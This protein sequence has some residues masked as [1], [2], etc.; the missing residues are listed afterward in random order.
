M[1]FTTF[2]LSSNP[3]FLCN[4][5]VSIS[6][7][8]LI[9]TIIHQFYFEN[10]HSAGISGR[11]DSINACLPSSARRI[12]KLRKL[13][14]SISLVAFVLIVPPLVTLFISNTSLWRIEVP[15]V[16]AS[17]LEREQS[18]YDWS[19]ILEHWHRHYSETSWLFGARDSAPQISA[20]EQPHMPLFRIYISEN[21][22]PF[23]LGADGAPFVTHSTDLEIPD[24]LPPS[25]QPS[26]SMSELLSI[27]KSANHH[28]KIII[29]LIWFLSSV[30]LIREFAV[31]ISTSGTLAAGIQKEQPS[32][33]RGTP[34]PIISVSTITH[35]LLLLL[36]IALFSLLLALTHPISMISLEQP[37]SAHATG[38]EWY[39]SSH[40]STGQQ[41]NLKHTIFST[42]FVAFF[43]LF[44][45][46]C[47]LF[48]TTR[49]RLLSLLSCVSLWIF[50]FRRMLPLT[51]VYFGVWCEW[52]CILC[53]VLW[54]A[55][56]IWSLWIG[57]YDVLLEHLWGTAKRS[58]DS[59]R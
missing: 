19:G 14:S 41:I 3:L 48:F 30:L 8:W 29:G 50:Q 12:P 45:L 2:L 58:D 52:T 16:K 13:T 46:V 9:F 32:C 27:Q 18:I 35:F 31:C 34:I 39:T 37:Q 42:L 1:P 44:M 59:K 49:G 10:C 24:S 23:V 33:H 7:I 28:L 6:Q 36:W 26:C 47:H 20:S 40:S 51:H 21:Y 17:G 5:I 56:Q 54:L 55:R 22:C 53:L 57:E 38:F 43:N 11:D 25:L 4:I 15:L